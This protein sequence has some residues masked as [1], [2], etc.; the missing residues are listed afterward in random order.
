MSFLSGKVLGIIVTGMGLAV[1]LIQSLA[2]EKNRKEL[3]E[4]LKEE[5][6]DELSPKE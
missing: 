2:D 1:T 5:I 3:K 6:M 4:E